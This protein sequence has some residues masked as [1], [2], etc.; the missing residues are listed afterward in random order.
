VV[1]V[2]ERGLP[3]RRLFAVNFDDDGGQPWHWLVAAEQDDQTGS[4]TAHAVAG[5]GGSW[6]R[7]DPWHA[8]EPRINLAGGWGANGYYGGGAIHSAGAEVARVRLIF[9]NGLSLE[10]DAEGDLAL[11]LT[12]Q[13]VDIP[14]T[15]E[16]LD[17]AGSVLARRVELEEFK[18][19]RDRELG[20]RGRK[21]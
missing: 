14:I 18:A 8:S 4:W 17:A 16:F 13:Q 12:D 15:V 11:F 3:R 5:G 2:K 7:H 19:R 6:G 1:F 10:D 9:A 21:P 20:R